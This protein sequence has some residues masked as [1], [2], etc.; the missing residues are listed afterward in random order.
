MTGWPAREVLE[1]FLDQHP[2]MA[3]LVPIDL[4]GML[5]DRNPQELYW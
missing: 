5:T 1:A 3:P 2:T 4:V